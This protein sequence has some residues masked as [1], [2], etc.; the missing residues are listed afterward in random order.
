MAK[1]SVYTREINNENYP[2]G[3]AKAVHIS[4]EKDGNEVPLN[5]NYGILFAQGEISNDNTI[6]PLGIE[7][8][9]IYRTSEGSYVICGKRI[10]ET[11]EPYEADLGRFWGWKTSD[12]KHFKTLGLIDNGILGRQNFKDSS[13]KYSDVIESDENNSDAGDLDK[14]YFNVAEIYAKDFLQIENNIAEAA[15]EY[16][17]P[18][19]SEA[20]PSTTQ[21]SFPLAKG[22]GDP[23]IFSWEGK[24]YFISTNDNT[25]D[26]GLYVRESDTVSG[27]F[28]ENTK[29]H[30]ILPYDPDRQLIQTFW[31]PEFHII[32]GEL[33]ILF[34]VSGNQW[35]PQCHLM[36]FNRGGS[37]I[38]PKSW[39]DPVRIVRKDGAPL[40][41]NAITLDMTYIKAGS[42]SYVVW[43][44]REHI[45]DPLDTGSML[46]IATI[47]EKEPW[48]LTS[49]PVLMS[50]PLFGWENVAGTINNEGPNAFIRDNKV[51]LTYSGG[52][53]NAYTYAVGLFTADYDAD[54]LD[55][56][57][58]KKENTPIMSFYSVPEFGPG[59]NSFFTDENGNLMIA[60]HAETAIDEH[61]RCDMIRKVCFKEDGTPYVR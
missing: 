58:W 51:Y 5:C 34:A 15:L 33:Y 39:S 4:V 29:Q 13:S 48:K 25:D 45:G 42:G 28:A 55:L 11:G 7:N 50:R 3:L 27:L 49:D 12:F 22:Y 10:L 32:G 56:N 16:W 9:F 1:L 61:L 44:Y 57:S 6:I 8:P 19:N 37:I 53:A 26:V 46:Y 36:K 24:W 23:V 31:A 52:S 54:L 38:D 30:L 40:A 47:D 17:N 18:A 20:S 60:Y 2:F 59:H 43:S 21:Y 41:E 14:E 35:G